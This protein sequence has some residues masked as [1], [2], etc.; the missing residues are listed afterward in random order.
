M[1]FFLRDRLHSGKAAFSQGEL[2][3]ILGIYGSRVQR[4]EWRDYAIDSLKDMAV[5]SIFRSTKENPI[6]TITKV[7]GRSFLK[8]AQFTVCTGGKVLRQ[9]PSL[10]DALDFFDETEKKK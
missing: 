6:Y 5:F 8:P 7:P 10:R 2:S 1:I 4:G 3:L 9:A